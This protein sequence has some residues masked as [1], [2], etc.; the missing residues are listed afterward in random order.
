MSTIA[1]LRFSTDKQDERQQLNTIQKYLEAKGMRIDKTFMDEGISGGTSYTKRNLFNLCNDIKENDILVVSEVSRITRSGI[2]ELSEIIEKYFKPNH[3]R[4]I[5]C[6]VGLDIDCSDINPMVEMQLMMLATFSKI[7]KQ[8][9]QERTKS[10]LETR[11]KKL[12]EEGSFISKK[13]NVCTSLGRPKGCKAD[14]KAIKA[15]SEAKLNNA[16][17]NPHNIRFYQYLT[18]FEKREGRIKDADSVS[19]FVQELAALDFRTA[20]GLPF[21]VTRAWNM[22]YKTRRIFSNVA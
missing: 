14:E 7:E 19:A 8:L 3:L 5:I 22:I 12:A 16:K 4:L 9:I 11:K 21:N 6:N 20:N 18:M 13:G 2:A 10:A 1:Y 15:M 17:N